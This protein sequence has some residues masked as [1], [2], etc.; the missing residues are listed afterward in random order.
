MDG[1]RIEVKE[2]EPITDKGKVAGVSAAEVL[3]YLDT[4]EALKL[5][6]KV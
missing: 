5:K 6:Q 3:W 4:A 1:R 2:H